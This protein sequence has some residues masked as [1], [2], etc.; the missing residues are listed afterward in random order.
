[1]AYSEATAGL[2]RANSE[3]ARPNNLR[4]VDPETPG[5]PAQ[6]NGTI[7]L[8]NGAVIT[9]MQ[10]IGKSGVGVLVPLSEYQ[11]P[12]GTL[13]PNGFPMATGTAAVQAAF[14]DY[15]RKNVEQFEVDP[16][17]TVTDDAGG[18][19]VRH[20]GSGTIDFFVVSGVASQ[21]NRTAL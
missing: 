12:D 20:V 16:I 13:E 3:A 9:H 1:M 17:V 8:A 7:A 4:L 14:Q 2:F 18:F 10:Y 6:D 21:L 19:V 5:T 11:Y 15:L